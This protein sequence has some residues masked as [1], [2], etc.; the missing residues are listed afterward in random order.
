MALPPPRLT[1]PLLR[2]PQSMTA[3]LVVGQAGRVQKKPISQNKLRT[4]LKTLYSFRGGTPLRSPLH[5]S[6][7]PANP[8]PPSYQVDTPRPSPRTNRT[9]RVP[10]PPGGHQLNCTPPAAP[11]LMSV[12]HTFP[13]RAVGAVPAAELDAI[14]RPTEPRIPLA[15]GTCQISTEGWTRRVHFVREGGGGGDPVIDDAISPARRAPAR[16]SAPR[17]P[18]TPRRAAHPARGERG[19]E[20]TVG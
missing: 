20:S 13:G 8:A 15:P 16:A 14:V 17:R 2:D 6:R 7:P 11:P 19:R 5:A 18:R 12:A 9:R 3:C 1:A 10:Q 4:A